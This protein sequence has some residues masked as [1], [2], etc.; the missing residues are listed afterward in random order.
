MPDYTSILRR[1]IS[2][3]PDASPQLR[4]AV[5]QRARAA[6]ARQLTA[7]DP[8][9]SPHEIEAQQQQLED[10]VSVI[11]AE[12]APARPDEAEFIAFDEDSAE[13]EPEPAPPPRPV[14]REPARP[15]QRLPQM[16]RATE[17]RRPAAVDQ[18]PAEAW[19]RQEDVPQGP[20]VVPAA[21]P[22]SS[23]RGSAQRS[24]RDARREP[25]PD[26]RDP[27]RRE[28]IL[29][30]PASG[31]AE[32]VEESGD[33][34]VEEPE[35]IPEFLEEDET[36]VSTARLD[37]GPR[38]GVPAADSAYPDDEYEGRRSRLPA[39]LAL[40]V[41]LLVIVGGGALLYGQRDALTGLFA[42]SDE[43]TQQASVETPSPA[44]AAP[45]TDAGG[46][47]PD[48]LTNGAAPSDVSEAETAPPSADGPAEPRPAAETPAQAVPLPNVIPPSP[49]QSGG[50]SLSAQR[51]IFYEQG[52]EGAPG[53]A[54]EGTI[55][56]S[57]VPAQDGSPAIQASI[58][59]ADRDLQAVITISRNSDGSLPA[60]H[61]V[62]VQLDG[63]A[64]LG[65]GAVERVP[66]LVLKPNEQA[67]GQPLAGAAVP[68]T[69]TLF[70]IALSDDPEQVTRNLTLMRD[71]SW[72]DLPVLFVGGKRALLTFEKGIP[73]DK[74]FETVL[75]AWPA[76]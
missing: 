6:L 38:G 3:L 5:Y 17:L 72:F 47:R 29:A 27:V 65:S 31:A 56:W 73:G 41:V 57:Q 74:V 21:A 12:H 39:L 76:N 40:I 42:Q 71:G 61:L 32:P 28:P 25:T 34:Q 62:E 50:E 70:W 20:R 68:V 19:D 37:R 44:P 67:R 54:T 11:E 9:L 49:S 1:S 46:K 24:E 16:P 51:A 60:S 48:R 43:P 59:I 13:A 55:A 14:L 30:L 36:R 18:P 53:R 33:Y 4:E 63:V 26:K 52:A 2:A 69:D 66:A 22:P 35:R 75:A 45:A 10:A 7:V 64:E 58:E 23:D 8:P 15:V